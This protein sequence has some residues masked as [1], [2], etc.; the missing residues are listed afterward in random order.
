[1]YSNDISQTNREIISHAVYRLWDFVAQLILREAT[2]APNLGVLCL[3]ET[4]DVL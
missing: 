4:N 1:M 3:G 2:S